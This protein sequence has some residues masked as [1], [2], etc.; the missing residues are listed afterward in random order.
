MELVIWQKQN[1]Q[2]FELQINCYRGWKKLQLLWWAVSVWS[3]C[4]CVTVCIYVFIR[5]EVCVYVCVCVCLCVDLAM[6]VDGNKCSVRVN[7]FFF[8]G[9]ESFLA[10]ANLPPKAR[11]S[12]GTPL[13][14]LSVSNWME[15]KWGLLWWASRWKWP[16]NRAWRSIETTWR[17][18]DLLSST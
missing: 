15:V 17:S 3:F 7:V 8:G 4:V 16:D 12:L 18:R 2:H 11:L 9:S 6:H 10:A 1:P 14:S 5:G 13:F